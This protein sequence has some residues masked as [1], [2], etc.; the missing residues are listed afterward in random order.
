METTPSPSPKPQSNVGIPVAIVL[1]GAIIAAALYF[2]SGVPSSTGTP[3]AGP[4]DTT[5]G[6]PNPIVNVTPD[7]DDPVLGSDS[8]AI[9]MIEFSDFEC[10]F[11]KQYHDQTFTQLKRDYI[12]TGK[13]KYV[14]KHFP[15][16]QLHP[17]AQKAAEAAQ[18]AH[19]QGKFWE[20]GDLL[21]ANQSA[22]TD[23]DLKRYAGQLRLNAATFTDCLTSGKHA[24]AV[25]TD[26]QTGVEAQV[27]GTPTFVID[28]RRLD[29]A[30]PYE[31]FKQTID[32]ALA[33]T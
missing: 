8:A 4:E 5:L 28:N 24:A 7:A 17:R 9:T 22:L 14:F 23:D 18:C 16:S 19:D 29:G 26:L 27:A 10:P 6:T 11:C 30:R 21:F 32:A 12:D 13:V 1:A 33:N 3:L 20:Y 15:L 2:R 31:V 25:S